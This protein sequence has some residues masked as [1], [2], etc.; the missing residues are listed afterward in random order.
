L[1]I[2]AAVPAIDLREKPTAT[3]AWWGLFRALS[4]AGH[5]MLVLPFLGKAVDS[6]WW[7]CLDNPSRRFSAI[8]YS[9]ARR[10]SDF[11]FIK[12]IYLEQHRLLNPIPR[13][14]LSRKWRACIEKTFV[15]EGNIDIAIFFNVPFNLLSDLPSYIKNRFHVPSI[16]FDADLPVSLPSYGGFHL[17]YY[18]GA[19]LSQFDGF[20]T[21]S[22]GSKSALVDMGAHNI[23]EVHWGVDPRLYSP[24]DADKDTD[25]FF[26]GATS[27]FRGEWLNKMVQQPALDLPNRIF[28]ISGRVKERYE[29]VNMLGFLGFDSWKRQ[30]SATKIC[31]NISRT[32][33]ATVGGTSTTRLFELASMAAC[34]VSNPHEGLEN[35]FEP[36]K[37]I[38]ILKETDR[39]SEVYE[40]LLGS[41]QL[42]REM[43]LRARARVLRDHTCDHRAKDI[44][45]FASKLL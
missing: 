39:P 38:F 17:S 24:V 4:E 28:A 11:A 16:Y 41:P 33:H 34:V 19:N 21:T 22:E 10:A 32:P 44:A 3:T 1:K 27:R 45:N 37:E 18:L 8:L 29:H 31:L 12:S 40:W 42:M 26:Y 9:E 6:P 2:F 23:A 20:L 35:W 15:Q 36:E 43:G 13:Q 25:V 14:I 7:R 5:Q 30:I